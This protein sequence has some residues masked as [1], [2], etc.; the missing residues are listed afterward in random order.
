MAVALLVT[1]ACGRGATRVR[2][3]LLPLLPLLPLEPRLVA[4]ETAAAAVLSVVETAA[5]AR[6]AADG[7]SA[8]AGGTICQRFNTSGVGRDS[9]TQP[10]L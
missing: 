8:A 4:E 6:A 7:G 1:G 9:M 3:T 5:V 10:I 2:P